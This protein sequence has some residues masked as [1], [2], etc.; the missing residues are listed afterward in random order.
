[1]GPKGWDAWTP[2]RERR[3]GGFDMNAFSRAFKHSVIEEDSENEEEKEVDS[4]QSGALDILME[5]M[6][7]LFTSIAKEV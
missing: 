5:M 1:M 3:A 2:S 6:V 4:N 7:V